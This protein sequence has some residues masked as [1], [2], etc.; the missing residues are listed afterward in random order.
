M[1]SESLEL[2]APGGGRTESWEEHH[3]LQHQQGTCC[4]M[5]VNLP[6]VPLAQGICASHTETPDTID[7]WA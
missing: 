5:R 7:I 2:G 3:V 1:D 6:A 4:E